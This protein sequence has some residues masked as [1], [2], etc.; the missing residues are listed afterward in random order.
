MVAWSPDESIIAIGFEEGIFILDAKSLQI[1]KLLHA[2][3]VNYLHFSPDGGYLASNYDSRLAIWDVASGELVKLLGENVYFSSNSSISRG[4][5]D[6]GDISFSQDGKRVLFW[7]FNAS[8]EENGSLQ[9]WDIEFEKKIVGWEYSHYDYLNASLS[10]DG[11]L[12]ALTKDVEVVILDVESGEIL[13]VYPEN[14]SYSFFN[15]TGEKLLSGNSEKLIEINLKTD[16]QQVFT[17][18]DNYARVFYLNEKMFAG[19]YERIENP[20]IFTWDGDVKV[21]LYISWESLISISISPSGNELAVLDKKND[22]FIWNI[23]KDSIS[24][25]RSTSFFYPHSIFPS[26][27]GSYLILLINDRLYLMDT[28]SGKYLH[29]LEPLL[30]NNYFFSFSP[31]G[32]EFAAVYRE[33][34]AQVWDAE[35]GEL[36]QETL[37]DEEE[38][39]LQE[40]VL[41]YQD[42]E[43]P[44]GSFFT[45]WKWRESETWLINSCDILPLTCYFGYA[46][47]TVIS[48][49][50]SLLA[51]RI[52]NDIHLVD[53]NSGTILPDTPQWSGVNNYTFSPDGKYFLTRRFMSGDVDVWD[54]ETYELLITL[55][56][57]G[58]NQWPVDCGREFAFS[59]DG[60]R[61]LSSN[62]TKGI[63]EIWD[64][65]GWE[66]ETSFLTLPQPSVVKISGDGNLA[67]VSKSEQ[68]YFWHLEE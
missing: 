60:S 23:E 14:F 49:D 44:D 43:L 15:S 55:E 42:F 7:G 66:M 28:Y 56:Y 58:S 11:K 37:V 59:S 22:L 47:N 40:G 39:F 41:V 65:Q 19:Y 2:L 31:S 61:L 8:I 18:E 3:K 68:I 29:A 45:A 30:S 50:G 48:A 17:N 63:I 21:H 33:L 10:P 46:C 13:K 5:L 24:R 35:S 54:L 67:V 64:T 53:A 12:V 1:I 20:N 26:Q 36:L 4:I 27:D 25:R 52:D 38:P 9:V 51:V 32:H 16:D 6:K 34:G 57:T 62:R